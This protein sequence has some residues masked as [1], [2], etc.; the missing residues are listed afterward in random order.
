M[1]PYHGRRGDFMKIKVKKKSYDEVMALPRAKHRPPLKP[2]MLFRA[3]LKIVSTPDLWATHFTCR[4]IGMEKLGKRE[5]CLILMNHASFIDLK[6]ASCILYPRPF[7]IVCTADGMVGKRWL[8]RQLGCIPTQKYVA[9]MRLLRDMVYAV[10]KKK[11]SVLMYPE[12]GYSFDRSE[13]RR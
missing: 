6:I 8:M 12:A 4:R 9:D 7:N 3:L 10:R 13:E 11:S 1:A 5:P 2:N